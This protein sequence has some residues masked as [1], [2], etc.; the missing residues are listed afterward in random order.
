MMLIGCDFH[1]SWQQISWFDE[2][3][4]EIGEQKLVHASGDAEK[5][6]RQRTAPAGIGMESTANCRGVVESGTAQGHEVWVAAAAKLRASD[7]RRAKLTSWPQ[8][9]V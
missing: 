1:P 6:Y 8:D 5:L 3:T 9:T 7:G 4:G 2:A